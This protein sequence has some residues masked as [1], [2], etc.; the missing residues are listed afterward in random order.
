MIRPT[1]PTARPTATSLWRRSAHLWRPWAHR[2]SCDR[3]HS[4]APPK[5]HPPGFRSPAPV[6]LPI[7]AEAQLPSTTRMRLDHESLRPRHDLDHL[8]FV[9]V[10]SDRLRALIG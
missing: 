6:R 7:S 5:P 8:G 4:A 9:V 2:L 1:K 10:G 3:T